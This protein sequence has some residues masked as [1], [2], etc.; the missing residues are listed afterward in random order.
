MSEPRRARGAARGDVGP[1]SAPAVARAFAPAKINPTLVVLGRRGDGYHEVDTTLVA[2]DLCDD[3]TVSVSP[4]GARDLSVDVSGPM[5]SDD[6]PRDA[7]NLAVRALLAAREAL[8]PRHP[9]LSSASLALSLVKRIPSQAGLGGGSSDAAAAVHA[10]ERAVGAEL[11][12]DT[13][14][15]LLTRLGADCVFFD[16]AR[17]TGAARARGIGER[18]ELLPAPHAWHVALVTPE[19]RCPTG[20]VYGALRF[21][22]AAPASLDGA[23]LLALPAEASRA[24]LFNH[25]ERAALDAV[26]EL[27]PWRALF[28]TLAREDPVLGTFRLSGSGSSWF[29]LAPDAVSAGALLARVV[30]GA[31]EHGLGLRVAVA[32]QVRGAG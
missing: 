27:R 20:L 8:A 14:R 6:V 19:A 12:H 18:I 24:H 21:P 4:D 23:H 15:Q 5:A 22:L 7:R 25:L 10:L 26:P 30:D 28:D 31:R 17:A 2:L 16:A 9:W 11:A 3:L 1:G 29:A 13:R 32:T